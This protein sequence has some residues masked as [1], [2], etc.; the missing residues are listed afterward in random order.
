[1]EPRTLKHLLISI[2]GFIFLNVLAALHSMTTVGNSFSAAIGLFAYSF[3]GPFAG[4]VFYDSWQQWLIFLI[5]I[6]LLLPVFFRKNI[7]TLVLA[8]VGIAIWLLPNAIPMWTG[9]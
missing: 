7:W 6:F 9:I 2:S 3:W 4:W 5:V 8:S 1:M